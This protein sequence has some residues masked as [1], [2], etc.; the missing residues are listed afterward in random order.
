MSLDHLPGAAKASA[1]V[2]SAGIVVGTL[3]QWLPPIAA[4]LSI[5]WTLIC[6]LESDTVRR[7]MGRPRRAPEPA[8][9]PTLNVE[10]KIDG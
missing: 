2:V 6:I 9:A 10:E 4:A 5:L 3:A 1:D 7:L 8:I